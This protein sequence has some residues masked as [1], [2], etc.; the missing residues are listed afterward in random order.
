[1]PTRLNTTVSEAPVHF[2][3]VVPSLIAATHKQVIRLAAHEVA[4]VIGIGERILTDRLVE[5]EKENPSAMGEGISVT[6]LHISGLKKSVNIFIRL[7]NPVT[8]GA[9]DN[10]DV[11]LIC[12]LLTPE[13]E[14]ASYLR[15]MARISRLL[16][17]AQICIKLRAAKSEKEI[18]TIL[19]QSSIQLMAA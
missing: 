5:E 8:M 14:G 3:V 6:H 18:R 13:R 7:K 16:R 15:T 19:D 12:L 9:P 4:K 10:K 1:M 17:N 2:D 11:D